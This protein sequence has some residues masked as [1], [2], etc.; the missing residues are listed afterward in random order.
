M[1]VFRDVTERKEAEKSRLAQARSQQLEQQMAELERLNRLKDEFLSTVSH[2]LRTPMANIKMAIKMLESILTPSI[3]FLP[4]TAQ[5]FVNRYI[6]IL[7]D[8]SRREIELINNLLDLQRLEE[9][10]QT[11]DKEAIHFQAL[12]P[13]LIEPFQARTTNR[14]QTLQVHVPTDLLPYLL[15]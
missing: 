14:Q 11:I 1:I 15:T 5:P 7:N 8:E 10:V 4:T 2:E 13:Q 3:K 9:K 6:Q 12:L